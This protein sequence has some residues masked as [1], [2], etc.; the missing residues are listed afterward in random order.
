MEG[1]IK[2]IGINCDMGEGFGRWKMVRHARIESASPALVIASEKGELTLAVPF[3][4]TRGQMMN[5]SSSST[6]PIL[7]AVFTLEILP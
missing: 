7:P 2:K 6:T 1:Y 4:I 3:P 5:S